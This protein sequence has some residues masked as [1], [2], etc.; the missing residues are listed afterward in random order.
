MWLFTTVG[1]F[2]VVRKPVAPGAPAGMLVVR[3]R[4]PGDLEALREKYMPELQGTFY[5]P[6][7]DYKYR[8][9]ITH[10]D[11]A[12]GL[13]KIALDIDYDNFKTEVSIRQGYDRAH[14]YMGVW[15]AAFELERMRSNKGPIMGAILYDYKADAE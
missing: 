13:A 9:A 2:S 7:G 10:T 15:K 11:F 1:F 3:A 12:A 14:V 6:D 5:T 8:A 4:V